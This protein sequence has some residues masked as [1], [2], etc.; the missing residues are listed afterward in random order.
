MGSA[1]RRNKPAAAEAK[2]FC[3]LFDQSAEKGGINKW[4]RDARS[5]RP[6]SRSAP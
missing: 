3:D 2:S 5:R 4:L 1:R 6:G